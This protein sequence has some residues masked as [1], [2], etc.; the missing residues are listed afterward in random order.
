METMAWE[1]LSMEVFEDAMPRARAGH[2][3]V[4]IHTR[5]WI[6]SGRDGYRKAWN[7]Q[8]CCKDLWYLETE[9]PAAPGRVQL[10]RASTHSL[11][12]CWGSVPTAD[13]YLLQVQK[14]DMPAA[15]TT[16]TTAAAVT[17]AA[18]AP[19][20]AASS[21]AV[22]QA[23]TSHLQQQQ[24]QQPVAIAQMQQQPIMISAQ[25]HQQQQAIA[26][27]M[28]PVKAAAPT[29]S[30]PTIIRMSSSPVGAP[31][32]SS[33]ALP[34][35]LR[36]GATNIVRVRAPAQGGGAPLMTQQQIKVMGAG[37]QTHI[38]KAA[39]GG[40][41]SG[42]TFGIL[43]QQQQQ[44]QQQQS[45]T[46]MSGIAALAA[47]AAQQGKMVTA[48]GQQQQPTAIKLVQGPAAGTMQHQTIRMTSSGGVPVSMAGHQTAIIGGQTVRLASPGGPAAAGTLLKTS[49]GGG[50]ATAITG[51]G[52]KQI[53][54]QKQAG[55]G[56]MPGTVIGSSTAG[57]MT[58]AGGQIVTLVKTSQGM[59]V[60]AA[61]IFQSFREF[62]AKFVCVYLLKVVTNEKG[63][64]V[65]EVLTIIC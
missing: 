8:V 41:A 52:G 38:I 34:G 26:N 59:Q 48:G 56:M 7:N 53:I 45:G 2:C 18:A 36:A 55:G 65:G 9:R 44:Q 64:A 21:P 63:E 16:T 32:G 30:Q 5:L 28:S 24:Q 51:P 39:P 54:L 29:M 14:Y 62:N 33:I 58:T 37:G 50:A 11:E 22:S 13:A 23:F 42:A 27:I 25:Q 20:M 12:V 49:G 40:G 15:V 4:S 60:G 1:S 17:P 31:A 61:S 57:G 43:S 3:A 19:A 6:W 46:N 10:V 47:A 35:G